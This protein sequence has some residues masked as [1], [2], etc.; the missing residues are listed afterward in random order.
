MPFNRGDVDLM[1][2]FA[3]LPLR[4]DEKF[5]AEKIAQA[6]GCP[7]I[8]INAC[9]LQNTGK[10]NYLLKGGSA[11][12]DET[13]ELQAQAPLLEEKLLSLRTVKGR[14]EIGRRGKN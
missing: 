10:A 2:N 6:T 5:H 11:Y 7:L 14:S 3:S 1:I 8:F 9:G 4:L 13:G 12:F